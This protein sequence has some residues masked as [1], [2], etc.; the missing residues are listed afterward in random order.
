M[1]NQQIPTITSLT[2]RSNIDFKKLD[3]HLFTE[4]FRELG[5]SILGKLDTANSF[6][7]L[8]R[9]FESPLYTNKDEY[10]QLYQYCFEFGDLVI[11]VHASYYEHVY[12]NVYVPISYRKDFFK[13]RN[14]FIQNLVKEQI[15][16]RI[17]PSVSFTL[18]DHR[19]K[20]YLTESQYKKLWVLID[21]KAKAFFSPEDYQIFDNHTGSLS[22]ELFKK[23]RPFDEF[24]HQEFWKSLSD[25][26][27]AQY[28]A[29]HPNLAS[30]PE[31]KAQFELFFHELK[32]GFYIRDVAINILGYESEQN[33]ITRWE[34]EL[35]DDGEK[36]VEN[37]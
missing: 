37:G 13:K 36:E 4:P 35:E 27:K 9:R 34:T 22:D 32:R 24:I 30:V 17:I 8:F 21:E 33:V 23:W 3:G 5:K 11:S 28:S 18:L 6:M 10:K 15:K 14:A 20:E 29:H 26:Q 12:F 25:D 1:A 19:L 31:L 7:Y 2:R 16:K